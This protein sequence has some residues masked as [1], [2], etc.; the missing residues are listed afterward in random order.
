MRK[1]LIPSMLIGIVLCIISCVKHNGPGSDL[2]EKDLIAEAKTNFIFNVSITEAKGA[3]LTGSRQHYIQKAPVWEDA[4]V[5]IMN[6]IKTVVVPI[7]YSDTAL[8]V[9]VIN[10]E[11]KIPLNQVAYL[12]VYRDPKTNNDL[13]SEVMYAVPDK[14]SNQKSFSGTTIIEKWDGTMLRGYKH[15]PGNIAKLS[16][17]NTPQT[18]YARGTVCEVTEWYTC[19]HMVGYPEYCRYDHTTTQCVDIPDPATGGSNPGGDPGGGMPG[20]GTG[21]VDG[22]GNIIPGTGGSGTRPT[23]VPPEPLGP[24]AIC[25]QSFSFTKA[26]SLDEKGFGGWQIAAVAGIHMTLLDS[27]GEAMLISPGPVI[28]FGLPI[29][30]NTGEFYSKDKAAQIA[31]DIDNKA[32]QALM[33]YY[34]SGVPVDFEGLNVQYRKALNAEAE[35]YGGR[36][37][38]TPGIGGLPTL[39]P[40]VAKY[41][42]CN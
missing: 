15:S 42:G 27:R 2:P 39:T 23:R 30:R 21:R 35:K 29:V 32:I 20:T 13:R 3:A 24:M 17:E 6:G 26:V 37:T 33:D 25:R 31:I 19:A 4:S 9:K 8:K 22:N 28:Y 36:A 7:Y 34:H 10:G 14:S 41:Y 1:R 5:Q 18:S 40:T 11:S 38:L 16:I 12:L